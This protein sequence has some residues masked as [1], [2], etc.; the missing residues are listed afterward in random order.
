MQLFDQARSTVDVN[1]QRDLMKQVFDLA[2]ESFDVIGVC[3]S[4]NLFGIASN[5]LRNV[6]AR[7]PNSWSW[8]HPG[9][10]LPQQFFFTS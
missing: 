5:R 9:P 1:R 6:P 10:A 8:P 3:L 7:M 4:T 2:A